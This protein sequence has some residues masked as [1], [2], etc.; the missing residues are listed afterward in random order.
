MENFSSK[1]K[2]NSFW[3][4]MDVNA[5]LESMP[6][7]RPTHR[8]NFQ[9]LKLSV[10]KAETRRDGFRNGFKLKLMMESINY[11]KNKSITKTP[12]GDSIKH[13]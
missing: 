1:K 8:I 2:C 10:E 3:L 7:F 11:N 13:C 9:S 5:R 4:T 6:K 12:N